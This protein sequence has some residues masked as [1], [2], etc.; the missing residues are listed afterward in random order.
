MIRPGDMLPICITCPPTSLG[1]V[2]KYFLRLAGATL[3]YYG[4]VTKLSLVQA[5]SKN[6]IKYAQIEPTKIGS[7]TK[8][9]RASVK[10]YADTWKPAIEARRALQPATEGGEKP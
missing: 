6:G 3:P 9:Q 8:E 2:R 5:V 7:L 4:V 1:N 10:G